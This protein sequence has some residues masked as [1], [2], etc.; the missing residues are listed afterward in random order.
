[1]LFPRQSGFSLIRDE[2][3]GIAGIVRSVYLTPALGSESSTKDRFGVG[4]ALPE[5]EVWRLFRRNLMKKARGRRGGLPQFSE[6]YPSAA[7]RRRSAFSFTFSTIIFRVSS[8]S[9]RRRFSLVWLIA[10]RIEIALG[11]S[12]DLSIL[13]RSSPTYTPA[14]D[15]SSKREQFKGQTA[16]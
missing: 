11:C 1:M 16:I 7:C 14:L 4:A 15:R 13:A 2:N 12:R 8:I 5:T 6:T 10:R 9:R 3:L